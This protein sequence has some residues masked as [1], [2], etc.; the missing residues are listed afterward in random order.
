MIS[1]PTDLDRLPPDC[2]P[3]IAAI[4]RYWTH[5]TPRGRLP[6]RQHFE[7]LDVP[8]LLPKIWL[9]D[10]LA[11]PQ[12]P[13]VW[14]FR[15]RLVGTMVVDG[16]GRDPTGQLLHEAWPNI[17]AP[18][19]TYFQYVNVVQNARISFRR[20]RPV[21]DHNRDYHWLERILLPLARDGQS[22]DMVL[23]LSTCISN[24]N[25]RMPPAIPTGPAM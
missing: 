12:S 8:N 22:V 1:Q 23:A 4:V 14:H 3:D 11:A 21:F 20:G 19:G 7:P 6:G 16:F 13:L 25:Y 5:I 18:D 15:H 24:R 9:L 17:A 2:Q 10:V